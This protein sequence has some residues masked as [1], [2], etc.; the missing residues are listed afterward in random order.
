LSRNIFAT[1]LIQTSSNIQFI[2]DDY[3]ELNGNFT[4]DG[5]SEFQA[6]IGS[7]PTGEDWRYDYAI[8]D[9]LGN[10]RVIFSDLNNS[11]T[12]T[13]N[14]IIAEYQYYPLGLRMDGDWAEN[15]SLHPV[16]FF[17]EYSTG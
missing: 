13:D 5:G 12:I 15:T 17:K 6:I 10:T 16:E 4:V 11:G 3:I 2:A 1:A 8:T 9:H 7:G 14:E